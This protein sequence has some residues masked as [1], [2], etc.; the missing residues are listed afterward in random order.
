[1]LVAI[2]YHVH[3][4]GYHLVNISLIAL[5][6]SLRGRMGES[7]RRVDGLFQGLLVQSFVEGWSEAFA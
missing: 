1:M 6:D 4:I 5:V 2:L 7:E 3:D